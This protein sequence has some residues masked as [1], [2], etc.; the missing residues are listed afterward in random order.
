MRR[1]YLRFLLALNQRVECASDIEQLTFPEFSYRRCCFSE[2]ISL[3][4]LPCRLGWPNPTPHFS[5]VGEGRYSTTA[6][7]TGSI[8]K[9]SHNIWIHPPSP[10]SPGGARRCSRVPV[11]SWSIFVYNNKGRQTGL[12]IL[13]C[14]AESFFLI[15]PCSVTRTEAAW[16]LGRSLS[17][18]AK[19]C[20]AG[21]QFS[22]FGRSFVG[23]VPYLLVKP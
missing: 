14:P 3:A 21:G 2:L 23:F 1:R 12:G 6:V 15:I 11:G 9:C 7:A 10:V 16:I 8:S 4:F 18:P 22:V 17:W 20:R 5:P 19:S 13:L